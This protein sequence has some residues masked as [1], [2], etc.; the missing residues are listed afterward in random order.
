MSAGACCAPALGR[1]GLV[2][3]AIAL[4]QIAGAVAHDLVV[5]K[6]AARA[7][8]APVPPRLPHRLGALRLG[9]EAG[10]ELWDRHP[11]PELDL[12]L[13][14]P[15]RTP[16]LPSKTVTWSERAI[17]RYELRVDSRDVTRI[18]VCTGNKFCLTRSVW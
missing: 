1:L 11:L 5:G 16:S 4:E 8:R 17:A 9:A 2:P 7:A 3:A 14:Q 18:V 12:V 10:H 13:D 6:T 15:L